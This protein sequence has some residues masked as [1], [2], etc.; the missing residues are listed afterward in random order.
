MPNESLNT[1]RYRILRYMPNLLREEWVNVG[2]LLEEVHGQAGQP[3]PRRDARLIEEGHIARVRRLHPGA[4][5]DLLRA[6]PDEFGSWLRGPSA[7]VG[8]YLE[9]LDRTLSNALQFSPQRA[10]LAEDFDAEL[11]RLFQEQVAPP[12]RTRG[13]IAES[14]RAWIKERVNDVF[15]RRRVP[16]LERNVPVEE[17]TQPGDTL[18]L[19][20]AFQN[21]AR[22]YLH[23]VTLGRDAAQAKVLA[24][25]AERIRLRVPACEF[26]AITEGEP[27]SDKPR[28]QFIERLF[29]EQGIAIVPLN[30][31]E[32]LA[33]DLRMRLQ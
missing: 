2:V 15:R 20:Y 8:A 27:V 13:G 9:K 17:F 5:A 12:R 33:E 31:I 19:D 28:H 16:K 25:T 4:D 11:D 23:A 22:G 14:T 26:H 32:R 1:Y 29:E 18:K 3:G 10:V 21:G 7:V 6:L 30:R 24:Y